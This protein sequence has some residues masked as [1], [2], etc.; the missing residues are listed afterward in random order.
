[1]ANLKM[2]QVS[3]CGGRGGNSGYPA[4]VNGKLKIITVGHFDIAV[5]LIAQTAANRQ[6]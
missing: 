5:F 2:R 4:L 1:M 3:L 6:K